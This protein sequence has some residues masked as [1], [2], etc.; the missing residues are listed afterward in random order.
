MVGISTTITVPLWLSIGSESFQR[1]KIKAIYDGSCALNW[2]MIAYVDITD[3]NERE[4][5]P[6]TT[7]K[8][9]VVLS[10]RKDFLVQRPSVGRLTVFSRARPSQICA[11]FLA[12][13]ELAGIFRD[14]SPGCAANGVGETGADSIINGSAI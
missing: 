3:A 14:R 6:G 7:Q 4:S 9:G 2:I 13:P 12:R 8:T 11:H 1:R 5:I 10:P